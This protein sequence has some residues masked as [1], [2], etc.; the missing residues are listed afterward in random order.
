MTYQ[1]KRK[2]ND[3]ASLLK[4]R[5]GEILDEYRF[6]QMQP[7]RIANEVISV[8]LAVNLGLIIDTH[9]EAVRA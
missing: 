2:P 1:I 3:P 7:I 9:Q 5:R 8:E 4:R 6:Y